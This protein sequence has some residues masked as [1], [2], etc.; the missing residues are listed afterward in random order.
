[1]L[2]YVR[3]INFCIIIIIII[4]GNI[5]TL[6]LK[7]QYGRF[8]CVSTVCNMKLRPIHVSQCVKLTVKN[9]HFC[10]SHT[11]TNKD[12]RIGILMAGYIMRWEQKVSIILTMQWSNPSVHWQSC[13]SNQLRHLLLLS[14]TIRDHDNHLFTKSLCHQKITT[15][16]IG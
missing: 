7:W 4:K 16:Y 13:L 9:T 10:M 5:C 15:S 12:C 1:M 11:D 14:N 3:A 6:Q 8:L 2:D